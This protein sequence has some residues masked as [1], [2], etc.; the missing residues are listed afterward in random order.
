MVLGNAKNQL[1]PARE[2]SSWR[3]C[4]V[5]AMLGYETITGVTIVCLPF[6]VFNQYAVLLHTG[7]GLISILPVAWYL[8]FHWTVRKEGNL[9]HYQ[10]LGYGSFLFLLV[11]GVSGIVLTI[12]AG[13][14]S[15]IDLV[16]DMVHIVTGIVFAVLAVIHIGMLA[17]RNVTGSNSHSELHHAKSI[18]YRRSATGGVG[19][20]LLT[21]LLGLGIPDIQREQPFSNDY[22]WR[23]GK[24]RPFAPSLAR[25]DYES[26]EETVIQAAIDRL[27]PSKRE[28]FLAAFHINEKDRQGFIQRL[29]SSLDDI[30]APHDIMNAIQPAI[31]KYTGLIQ[32]RGALSP[33]LMSGSKRCGTSGCHEQIYQEWLPNAHRYS[34]LDHLFQRTQEFMA[35]ETSPEQTRYCAGCHDPISLFGGAKNRSNITLSV[36]GADEGVSCIV[37]HSIVKTDTQGNADYMIR[38]PSPYLFETSDSASAKWISDFWSGP[39]PGIMCKPTR[40]LCINRRNIAARAISNISIPKSIPISAGCKVKT[41]TT[42]GVKAVGTMKRILTAR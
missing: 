22:N 2:W 6:S 36:E 4:V 7:I 38:P 17:V 41:N 12:Q 27:E 1:D 39:I 5:V 37:C 14:G 11:C 32:A 9:T 13:F 29:Q 30:D 23:F 18:F 24:D 10:L 16:W 42:V 28:P 25:L 19:F 20:L 8:Y 15:K 26:W 34:S 21:Y 35:V 33:E 3:T 31:D 40:E